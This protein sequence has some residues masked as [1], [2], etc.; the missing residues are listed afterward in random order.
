MSSLSQTKLNTAIERPRPRG[1]DSDSFT[2]S[3]SLRLGD[4]NQ[5]SGPFKRQSSLRP[6]DL[7]SI[8][9]A[10]SRDL[11]SNTSKTR[12]MLIVFFLVSKENHCV[13]LLCLQVPEEVEPV[14]S[15]NNELNQLSLL[16]TTNGHHTSPIEHITL[17]ISTNTI[18]HPSISP[19]NLNPPV[20][21]VPM[22]NEIFTKNLWLNNVT[23]L[24]VDQVEEPTNIY[25]KSNL[26][27]SINDA[28]NSNLTAL[29]QSNNPTNPFSPYGYSIAAQAQSPHLNHRQPA[30]FTPK[31]GT[32]PFD[33]D[34]IRR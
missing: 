1:T 32:N 14:S 16:E 7:P 4:W 6:S 11:P 12:L 20:N 26:P 8:Q 24:A 30:I 19:I 27:T 28:F 3:A 10:R 23:S 2:R 29:V 15:T 34:L 33:D 31:R 25:S 17:P 13:Y 22:T 21:T 5:S 9:E 18:E